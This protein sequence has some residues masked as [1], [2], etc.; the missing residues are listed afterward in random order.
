MTDRSR[1]ERTLAR[2]RKARHLYEILE[3]EVAGLALLGTEVKSVRAG[4]VNLGE[5]HVAFER[6]EAFLVGCHI[7]Q[8]PNSG[9]AD[10][11]PLRRRKL[12]LH[13]RQIVRL[14]SK[15]REK[16]L[17]VVPLSLFLEGNWIKIEIALVRGK[18]LYDKR[19]TLK[20]RTL[21][22]EADQ[23]LKDGRAKPR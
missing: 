4:R 23:A 3:T 22:R 10:H 15:V 21:E 17:T 1:Q 12:L 13:K 20:R 7:S 6:G 11:D 18:K 19:E 2:N 8:Y 16:G 14:A 5:A 9:Y